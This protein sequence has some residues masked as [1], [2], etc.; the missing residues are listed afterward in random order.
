MEKDTILEFESPLVKVIKTLTAV[1][2]KVEEPKWKG[3]LRSCI[4]KLNDPDKLLSVDIS[5]KLKDMGA[6]DETAAFVAS[7][8]ATG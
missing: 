5:Q 6:D 7:Q 8:V 2:R 4:A 1:M 3:Q